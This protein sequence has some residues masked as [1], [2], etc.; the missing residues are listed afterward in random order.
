MLTKIDTSESFRG[1]TDNVVGG[2]GKAVYSSLARRCGVYCEDVKETNA[3]RGFV[4]NY[5]D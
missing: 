5:L 3:T 4:F 1:I 2:D